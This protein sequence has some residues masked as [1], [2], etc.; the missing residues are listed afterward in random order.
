MTVA[1]HVFE[2]GKVEMEH[3]LVYP[4]GER[5]RRVQI[6]VLCALLE[7]ERGALLFD[8]GLHPDVI[9]DPIG[10]WGEVAKFA[11]P[12][13]REGEDIVHRLERLGYAP[14]RITFVANSHLHN[15]HAG[16]N[17][18]FPNST[19]LVQRAEL[20]AAHDAE[21]AAQ[22]GF[23]PRDWDHD[24]SYQAVNGEHDIFG[25]GSAVLFPTPGHTPGHQSLLVRMP[26]GKSYIFTG[27][28]AYV[29]EQ[30]TV[31][32]PPRI[33]WDRE[34]ATASLDILNQRATA[35]GAEIL[36]AHDPMQWPNLTHQCLA[37][38]G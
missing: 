31:R 14:D 6:P 15:D 9:T 37:T 33:N 36:C 20:D 23:D 38:A 34:L 26:N 28:A 5:G 7:H 10:R 19:F 13:M 35:A 2:C 12:L 17:Q 3:R 4:D 27:D 1:L 18:F 29:R 22:L 21:L 25:D 30:L 11:V 16:S 8:T 24:L 32:V